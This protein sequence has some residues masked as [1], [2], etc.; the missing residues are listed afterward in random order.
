MIYLDHNATT[1]C[2]SEVVEAMLPYFQN[3]F[4]NPSSPHQ[5]GK[6]AFDACENA[7]ICIATAIDC[8]SQNIVFTSGATESNNMVLLGLIGG[9]IVFIFLINTK[10]PLFIS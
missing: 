4:G 10:K 3:K 5:M 2:A 8:D 1:P 7:R 9:S 6:E